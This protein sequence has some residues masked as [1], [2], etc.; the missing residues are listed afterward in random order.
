MLNNQKRY[1]ERAAGEVGGEPCGLNSSLHSS[2]ISPSFSFHQKKMQK[3]ILGHR[4]G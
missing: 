3:R 4:K 2:V 1:K